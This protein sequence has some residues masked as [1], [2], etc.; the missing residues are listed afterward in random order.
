[1]ERNALQAALVARA[2]QW[3][4]G[5]LWWRG[6]REGGLAK[7]LTGAPVALPE[8]WIEE[9]NQAQTEVELAAL[10]RSV[11]RGQP[12]GEAGWVQ[13]LAKRLGL[14]RTLRPVGRPRKTG[15]QPK[16]R[17]GERENGS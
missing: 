11:Q 12:Y 4:W 7:L 1:V 13:R 5:S 8:T 17:G 16:K 3:R 2:E 15:Q 14:E 10:R 6:Q 9:V